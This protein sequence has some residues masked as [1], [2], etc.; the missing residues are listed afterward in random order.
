MNK[1]QLDIL[2]RALKG[3]LHCNLCGR[4]LL[5]VGRLIGRRYGLICNECVVFCVEI[6]AGIKPREGDKRE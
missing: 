3:E 4:N 2:E 5:A 1:K 6:L